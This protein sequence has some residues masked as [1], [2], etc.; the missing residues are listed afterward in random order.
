MEM[1]SKPTCTATRPNCCSKT[2]SSQCLRQQSL[3]FL[4]TRTL[5]S[6]DMMSNRGNVR[7][8]AVVVEEGLHQTPH[9][10]FHQLPNTVHSPT[11]PRLSDQPIKPV[12]IPH[13]DA[14]P[15]TNTKEYNTGHI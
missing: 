13:S 1:F 9:P 5:F 12:L 2:Q 11:H 4:P 7:L 14:V 15:P 10:P 8:S 6:W 3:Q